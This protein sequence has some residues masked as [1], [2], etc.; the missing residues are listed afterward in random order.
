MRS[1]N[2]DEGF[3]R[4]IAQNEVSQMRRQLDKQYMEGKIEDA[5][6]GTY[7]QKRSDGPEW[8]T[9]K[10]TDWLSLSL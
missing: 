3:E 2:D 9:N 1:D 10:Q 4:Q 8:Q 7:S 6:Q 5:V